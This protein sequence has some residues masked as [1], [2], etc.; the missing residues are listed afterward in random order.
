ME[1]VID[2]VIKASVTSTEQTTEGST[3]GRIVGGQD[4]LDAVTDTPVG[5]VHVA[6]DDEENSNSQVVVSDVSQPEGLGLRME[7]PQEGQNCCPCTFRSPEHMAGGI[8]ILS[9][10]PPVAGEEG[11]Q[12]RWVRFNTQ[13]VIPT[14]MYSAGFGDS[15]VDEVTGPSQGAYT[16]Q[17]SQV[18]IETGLSV[19]E[20]S[21]TGTEL[22]LQV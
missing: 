10:N 3:L 13:E 15:H 21:Q 12:A 5:A 19:F 16:E 1:G 14:H 4:V 2:G 22:R 8:G 20:P 11:S 18:V 7:S 17:P 9:I 6:G